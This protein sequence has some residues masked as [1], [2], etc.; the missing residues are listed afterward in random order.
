MLKSERCIIHFPSQNSSGASEL[1]D[2]DHRPGQSWNGEYEV[3]VFQWYPEEEPC[4]FR[5]IKG[6][7]FKGLK[8]VELE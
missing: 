4:V 6:K 5:L 2:M 8:E 1:W 7:R 3:F